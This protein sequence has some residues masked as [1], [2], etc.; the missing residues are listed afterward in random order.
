MKNLF[1]LALLF[2]C[3]TAAFLNANSFQAGPLGMAAPMDQAAAP[4][5]NHNATYE[6]PAATNVTP[7]YAVCYL[8]SY[9]ASFPNVGGVVNLTQ[10]VEGTTT[11]SGEITGLSANAKH[12][13][14]IHEMGDLREGCK[15]LSSHYNPTH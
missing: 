12:G 14:H 9:N 4:E 5:V 8:Q 6:H 10:N 2:S 13:F 7:A 11:L 3:T 15:S 1:V